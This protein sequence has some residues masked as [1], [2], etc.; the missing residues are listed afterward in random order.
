MARAFDIRESDGTSIFAHWLAL[1]MRDSDSH[2][3]R[4]SL[5]VD[6]PPQSGSF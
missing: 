4:L 6:E 2:A 5:G 3:S 1:A